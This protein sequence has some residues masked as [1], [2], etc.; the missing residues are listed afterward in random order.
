M[1]AVG[2][3]RRGRRRQRHV[4]ATSASRQQRRQGDA[5]AAVRR[6]RETPVVVVVVDDGRTARETAPA[7]PTGGPRTVA[8][9]LGTVDVQLP[10][11]PNH[12]LL[13]GVRQQA[14]DETVRKQDRSDERK[15]ATASGRQL[16]H[17]S[18][19]QLQASLSSFSH[20]NFH[21]KAS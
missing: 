2:R 1:S 18:M 6:P 11:G 7:A 14:G 3:D 4:S 9:H 15:T 16:G 13:S 12:R 21:L 5:H 17:T 8:E 19:Q 20:V 10:Q